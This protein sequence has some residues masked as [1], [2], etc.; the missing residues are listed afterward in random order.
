M[1]PDPI[2]QWR[3]DHVEPR[4]DPLIAGQWFAALVAGACFIGLL[5]W[6]IRAIRTAIT[7][8]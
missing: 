1:T 3:D 6:A 7:G 4:I 5:V 8:A 2:D